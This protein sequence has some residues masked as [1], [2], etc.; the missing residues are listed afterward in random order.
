VANANTGFQY[1][2]LAQT[3]FHIPDVYGVG[4]SVRPIPVLTINVDG[5]RVKYTNLVDDFVSSVSEL[6]AI[7]APFKANDATELHVGAEYFFSTKI[8]VALRAGYW[9]DPAHSTYWA[10]P[11]NTSEA[12]GAAMLYPRGEK[13]NHKS[14]GAGLAWPKFQIDAAYD[15]SPHYK[16]GSLSAVLRF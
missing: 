16:V 1:A 14:I 2:L 13:Q 3:Q 9:R 4:I 6:R 12:V 11:L 15:T 8:P 10:G 7:G 5:V